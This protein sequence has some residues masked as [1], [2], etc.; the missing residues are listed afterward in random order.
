MRLSAITF[1]WLLGACGRGGIGQLGPVGGCDV[2]GGFVLAFDPDAGGL[3]LNSP[4]AGVCK[5]EVSTSSLT[6]LKLEEPCGKNLACYW[7]ATAPSSTQRL[8]CTCVIGMSVCGPPPGGLPCCNGNCCPGAYCG[9]DDGG[10]PAILCYTD[11]E[12]GHGGVCITDGGS[13][14]GSCFW[15]AGGSDGN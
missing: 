11:N 2:D 13:Q 10:C 15:D 5:P 8:I 12:C 9:F 3:S 6:A 1:L 7:D 4:C 14:G